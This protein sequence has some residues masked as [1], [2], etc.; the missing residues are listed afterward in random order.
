MH[1]TNEQDIVAA[2]E[3]ISVLKTSYLHALNNY[4][5][6]GNVD[7]KESLN[8]ILACQQNGAA[9]FNFAEEFVG[10][11]DLLGAHQSA[12]WVQGFAEDCA[13][14]LKT[15]PAHFELIA[16]GFEK[17]NNLSVNHLRPGSTAYAN[18][19]RM[20]KMYLSKSE[21]ENIKSIFEKSNLPVYGFSNEAR[22]FMSKK[23]QTILSFCFG[24]A[25]IAIM[26]A[27]AIFLP[28]P[29]DFQLLTFRITLALAAGGITAMLPGFLSVEISN[30]IRASGALAGFVVIY[31]FNPAIF[32]IQGT[33]TNANGL[34]VKQ[35]GDE[36]GL[37][38]YYWKQ[39]DL[40]FRFPSEN[41]A[42]STKAA[43]AG[44]GD[45]TLQHAS[46]KDAQLQMHVSLLDDKYRGKWEEFKKNTISIWKG[47]I[48][49]I[50]KFSSED[51]YI[52]G[53]AAFIIHGAIHGEVQGDKKIDL[54]YAPLDD[55]R[56]FEM[57]LT[58][59]QN[60]PT[61][62]ELVAAYN[63]I[64]STIHFDRGN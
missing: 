27:I 5:N 31:F 39:A 12:L 6:L 61:E 35:L 20:V 52:D 25:F 60:I 57:H 29:T 4:V 23:L 45:L 8:A 37:V 62:T 11:S 38:E 19:Q 28:Y 44:L 59:N 33:P 56:L 15:M 17:L 49:H 54:V 32:T 16:A 34:F 64:K 46:G 51:V 55:N 3:K 24:V 10:N 13:E 42:E 58:R 41:W 53:R 36:K 9:Y 40:K 26:L 2:K 30:N 22:E 48:G 21:S 50:G 18:M 1:H 47:T 63:L 43:N 7:P 14:I